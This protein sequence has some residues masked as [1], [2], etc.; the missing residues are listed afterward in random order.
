MAKSG[1]VST[2]AYVEPV[3]EAKTAKRCMVCRNGGG[4]FLSYPKPV[5]KGRMEKSR[6]WR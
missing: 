3:N 1:A 6:D 4:D 5:P 2:N